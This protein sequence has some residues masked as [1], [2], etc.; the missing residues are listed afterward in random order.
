MRAHALFLLL[1]FVQWPRGA[2]ADSFPDEPKPAFDAAAR[3]AMALCTDGKG[4]YVAF[5]ARSDRQ[6]DV[7]F[8]HR[9][10]YGDGKRM[11]LVPVED[12]W[13]MTGD[14]FLDPRNL[15]PTANAS[16]RGIDWRL[17]SFAE[18][19]RNKARCEVQCGERRTALKIVEPA[20]AAALLDKAEIERGPR[21]F[22]P[23]AL[24]RDNEGVYYYVDNGFWPEAHKSYRLFVGRKGSLAQQKM[25]DVVTDS[26]GQIF[27]TRTGS[28]RLVL[29]RNESMWVENGKDGREK[30]KKLLLVPP[31]D[32]LQMI[33][34]DLGVYLGER[35]GTPCDDF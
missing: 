6:K 35:L 3:K 20:Q 11:Y 10:L 14:H 18:L 25:T 16:F 13:G 5:A 12:L 22:R 2:A 9:I 28:L 15:N 1:A 4:H 29:G 23:H 34:N 8:A 26:E 7:R 21:R 17:Y 31:Q 19:D 33:Y 32:N 24:A 27:A 30:I